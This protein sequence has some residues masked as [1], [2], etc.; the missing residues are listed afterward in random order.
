MLLH[1]ERDVYKKAFGKLIFSNSKLDVYTR[2]GKLCSVN[3]DLLIFYSPFIKELLKDVPGGIRGS[4]VLPDVSVDCL[5]HVFK[6][7]SNGFTDFASI[8]DLKDAGDILGINL[9]CL[10]YVENL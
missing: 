1:I 7:I 2:E 6:V 8:Q 5:Q 4:L 9:H 3:R 10:E